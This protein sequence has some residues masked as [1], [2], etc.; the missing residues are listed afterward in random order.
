[1]KIMGHIPNILSHLL[2]FPKG[3]SLLNKLYGKGREAHSDATVSAHGKQPTAST[4]QQYEAFGDADADEGHVTRLF[5]TL[6]NP[7]LTRFRLPLPSPLVRHI[8]LLFSFLS[9]AT[10]QIGRAH[11]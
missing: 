11:V 4:L 5:T 7:L 6:L 8:L 3:K 9:V 1:M 2:F 10:E